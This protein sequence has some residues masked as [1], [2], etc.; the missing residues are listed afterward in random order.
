MRVVYA[1]QLAAQQDPAILDGKPGEKIP[2]APLVARLLNVR[3]G[4]FVE[5]DGT[6]VEHDVAEGDVLL[7]VGDGG[8]VAEQLARSVATRFPS[9]LPSDLEALPPSTLVEI[10]REVRERNRDSTSNDVSRWDE[11]W[12]RLREWTN[13]QLLPSIEARSRT[14]QTI[15]CSQRQRLW[16]NSRTRVASH[17]DCRTWAWSFWPAASTSRRAAEVFSD[18][19]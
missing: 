16:P 14:S 17:G 4:S 19:D 12:H 10:R 8:E 13:G 9:K 7:L 6:L 11:T 2:T 5:G 15:S 3:T 1:L 18:V